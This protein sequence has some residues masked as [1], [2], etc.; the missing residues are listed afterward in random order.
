VVDQSIGGVALGASEAQVKDLYGDPDDAID[1]AVRS[2][3]GVLL[4]YRFKGGVMLV[5]L[6]DGRV[7]TVETTSPY[8]HTDAARGSW[9]PGR[10][11]S[12]VRLPNARP[13]R[14]SEGLWNGGGSKRVVTVVTRAGDR[15]ASVWITLAAYYDLC[16]AQT[17]EPQF[18][19]P[20]ETAPPAGPFALNIGPAERYR[21]GHQ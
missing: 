6:V 15:V 19:T 14:C 1:I 20:T 11:F 8:H 7:V 9:G 4:T 16:D 5:T 17:E 21:R 3:D 10:P 2:G 18:T 12:S 13:D